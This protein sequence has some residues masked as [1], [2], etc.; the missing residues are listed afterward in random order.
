[1]SELPVKVLRVALTQRCNLNCIYCHHEGECSQSDNGKKEITKEDIED[2]LKVSKDLGIKK[3][4]F[5]GGEPLLR[6]D[7]V[8]IVEIASKHMEDISISTNGTLL[9]EKVSDLK[10]AGISRFNITLN[11]LNNEIYKSIAGK[12]TLKDVLEGIEKTYEEKI[13]PIKVNMVVMQRNYR[14]IKEMINYTKEGMVLQLIEL[15][16]AKDDL[17]SD[18]YKENYASLI[19]IEEYLESH[20]IKIIEREKQ[21]RKKYFVPQEIEVVRSMHNTV[22]C[23]NCTSIRLTS[24][25]EI[26]NCLFRNDNLIK[27]KDFSDHEKLKETL[28]KSIKTKTPYWC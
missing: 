26:K 4:R 2:L 17:D 28:I 6:K 9:S 22:F 24:E 10:E 1:M 23:K 15:I 27:V 25:G 11:T 8:E 13:F 16:S 20:S 21:R 3:V 12:D 5:T 14:E 7:I 19:P 18:F